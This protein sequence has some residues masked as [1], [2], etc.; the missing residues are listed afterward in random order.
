MNIE[1]IKGASAEGAGVENAM[2]SMHQ[3]VIEWN[4]H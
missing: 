3:V 2:S 4:L 1:A